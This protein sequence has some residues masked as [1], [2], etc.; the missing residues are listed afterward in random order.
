MTLQNSFHSPVQQLGGEEINS[1][2]VTHEGVRFRLIAGRAWITVD[3]NDVIVEKDEL[4]H[5]PI[6]KHQIIIS[7]ANRHYPIQYQ[8]ISA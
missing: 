1:L 3:D 8:L 6:S 2:K 4:V 7:S 5:L